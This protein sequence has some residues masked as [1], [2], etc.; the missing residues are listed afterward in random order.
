MALLVKSLV[1]LGGI[2][3]VGMGV[4]I[5]FFFDQFQE[6]NNTINEKYF[7]LPR[8]RNPQFDDWILTQRYLAAILLILVGLFLLNMFFRYAPY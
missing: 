7:G 2:M 4:V 5:L 3:A 6:I 8:T 1:L